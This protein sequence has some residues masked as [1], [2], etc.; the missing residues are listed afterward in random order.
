MN[1]RVDAG[2]AV[3]A[4][5][6]PA[7][8]DE[9]LDEATRQT[10]AYLEAFE[11]LTAE[12][13]Q[14]VEVYERNGSLARSRRIISD[15]ILYRPLLN[16]RQVMEF[17][18][19]LSVD[20][21]EVAKR[22]ERLTKFFERLAKSGSA[23]EEIRRVTKES[24][25]YHPGYRVWGF[26]IRQGMPF[27]EN[28]RPV[29]RFELVGQERLAGHDVVVVRYEQK[30]PS[31]DIVIRRNKH[32]T[33]GDVE[34]FYRGR[35]WLDARTAQIWREERELA[36]RHPALKEPLVAMRM[37]F[38]Y[39]PSR[40]P[41]LLPRKIVTSFYDR[42]ERDRKKPQTLSLGG[43][44]TFEYGEFSVFNVTVGAE[45]VEPGVQQR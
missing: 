2:G 39:G 33:L 28:L 23:R 34:D 8:F 45:K 35:L 32:P 24:T 41:L 14:T 15:L 27:L 21:V 22:D 37:E 29:F 44:I 43:R 16:D 26:T 5:L 18:N 6:T 36:I 30:A 17:R 42:A 20:G 7:Q 4:T 40:F 3:A 11:N 19:V 12:E 1:S 9:L 10:A 38:D 13:T 25:R 31:K